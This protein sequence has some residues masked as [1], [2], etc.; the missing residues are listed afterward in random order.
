[1]KKIKK[2]TPHIFLRIGDYLDYDY[3]DEHKKIDKEYGSVWMLKIGKTINKKYL[4]SIIETNGGVILKKSIKK[5][6]QFYYADLI[7]VDIL[8]EKDIHYPKYYD[9]YLYYEGYRLEDILQSGY[10]FKLKNIREIDDDIV[11]KFIVNSNKKPMYSF[12]TNT[13]VVHMYISNECDLEI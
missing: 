5:G 13:R 7:S 1:M 3:I 10:W 12:A 11:N 6:N 9:E 8:N 2:D 4:D